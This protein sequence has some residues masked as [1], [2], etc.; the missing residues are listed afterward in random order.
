[1]LPRGIELMC[2]LQSPLTFHPVEKWCKRWRGVRSKNHTETETP[3]HA[4]LGI[5]GENAPEISEHAGFGVDPVFRADAQVSQPLRCIGP[6]TSEAGEGVR[7][8]RRGADRVAVNEIAIEQVRDS[9][10]VGI[11][12][13]ADP[14]ILGEEV[15][16][17]NSRPPSV[18]VAAGSVMP[19]IE[20]KQ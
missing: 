19:A 12:V 13:S 15:V 9:K 18:V 4:V 10:C 1:M 11:G 20:A 7:R 14:Q 3:K 2:R 8:Q 16:Q 6:L 17:P 5:F